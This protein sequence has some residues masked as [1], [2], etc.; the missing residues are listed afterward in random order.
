[1]SCKAC[2]HGPAVSGAKVSMS[3]VGV[4]VLISSGIV[5]LVAC[6]P[7]ISAPRAPT[8][9]IAPPSHS[10]LTPASIEIPCGFMHCTGAT[11][12]CVLGEPGHESEA[13]RCVTESEASAISEAGYPSRSRIIVR[14]RE[15]KDCPAGE[16]CIFGGPDHHALSCQKEWTPANYAVACSTDRECKDPRVVDVYKSDKYRCVQHSEMPEGFKRCSREP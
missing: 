6:G 11:P 15:T 10:A 1:M 2:Y 14:C 3:F 12:V 13:P 16:Y 5:L 4:P 8:T 9:D 7:S